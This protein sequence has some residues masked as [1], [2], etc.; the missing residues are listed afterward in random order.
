MKGPFSLYDLR[1]AERNVFSKEQLRT[2]RYGLTDGLEALRTMNYLNGGAAVRVRRHK[3]F[4]MLPHWYWFM[5]ILPAIPFQYGS[6][7]DSKRY[8]NF[9]IAKHKV[10]HAIFIVIVSYVSVDY[11]DWTMP[12]SVKSSFD[13]EVHADPIMKPGPNTPSSPDRTEL[14]VKGT[15]PTSTSRNTVWHCWRLPVWRPAMIPAK[16]NWPSESG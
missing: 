7:D 3:V 1:Y 15:E 16:M 6:Y 9:W 10:W 14:F 4:L 11:A 13:R 8:G 12:A 2:H 5:I